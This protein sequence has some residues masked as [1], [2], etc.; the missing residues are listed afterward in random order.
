M[1][2]GIWGEAEELRLEG[3]GPDAGEAEYVT[4]GE[5]VREVGRKR[6]CESDWAGVKEGLRSRIGVSP[7]G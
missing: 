6:V 4:A 7:G 5:V 1:R 3:A 2:R